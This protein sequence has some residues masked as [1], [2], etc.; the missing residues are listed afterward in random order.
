M[1]D[2]GMKIDISVPTTGGEY[3]DAVVV[4]EWLVQPGDSVKADQVLVVVE[5]AKT[6]IEIEAPMDGV[7]I[8]VLAGQGEEVEVGGVL[9]RFQA[10]GSSTHDS[11][12]VSEGIAQSD[13]RVIAS[14][15]A[16]YRAQDLGID[17][18]TVRP[19]SPSG[20]I[21]LRD[22]LAFTAQGKQT[23]AT[24]FTPLHLERRGKSS[25]SPIVLIH[26]FGADALGW[27]PLLGKLPTDTSVVLVELPGH[28]RSPST[29]ENSVDGIAQHVVDTLRRHDVFSA[30]LVGHSLGGAIAIAMA[31]RCKFNA[32][33]VGVIAPAGLGPDV[34]GQFMD[35]FTRANEA[36]SL[37][38]WLRQ[39]VVDDTRIDRGFAELAMQ[40]RKNIS[41]RRQQQQMA[42]QLFPDGTQR[43]DLRADLKGLK[44]PCRIIWGR[45]DRIIPWRHA[46][47][48]GGRVGLHLLPGVGHLPQFE[49]PDVVSQIVQELVW[50]V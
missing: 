26:G 41:L 18:S 39:L 50:S 5:T 32:L 47:A 20:R 45:E 48:A 35:G 24:T 23:H 12:P 4:L 22:L 11:K 38:P 13:D 34:N 37:H 16:R 49:A 28:G 15:A 6:S 43:E 17:L 9:G 29:R 3:M 36:A 10:S 7:L 42:E 40:Q 2:T 25:D 14:P 44:V 46:L 30:H 31:A 19:S 1:V 21:K 8:E 33:S 27:S